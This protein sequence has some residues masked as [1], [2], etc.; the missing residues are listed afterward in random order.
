MPHALEAGMMMCLA[1]HC[2][3]KNLNTIPNYI[4]L[5]VSIAIHSNQRSFL[6]KDLGPKSPLLLSLYLYLTLLPPIYSSYL[7]AL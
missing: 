2:P 4:I 6:V 3:Q 1:L 7:K 5:S